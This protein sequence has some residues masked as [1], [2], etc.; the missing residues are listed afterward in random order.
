MASQPYRIRKTLGWQVESL[1]ATTFHALREYY[2]DSTNW[3]E[4][5]VEN[6]PD[7]VVTRPKEGLVQQ[8][9]IFQGRQLVLISRPDRIDWN[10]QGIVSPS[11]EPVQEFPTLGPISESLDSFSKI[12]AKWLIISPDVTRL[13]F[14]AVLSKRAEDLASAY[15]ELSV[16]LP[17][18][19][20]HAVDAPDFLFQI[21]RPRLSTTSRAIKINRLNKWSVMQEG[22]ISIGIGPGSRPTLAS[23]SGRLA[24]RL[25]LDINTSAQS[26]DPIPQNETK[27]LFTELVDLGIEIAEKGDIP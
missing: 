10:L 7:Q 11:S 24:C 22:T 18:I 1:R 27:E 26:L 4:T 17:S 3:W 14:G 16:L 13:A 12:V 9:G 20:L 25:E 6:K 8:S 5:V 21:N 2:I 23:R 19:E 15:K